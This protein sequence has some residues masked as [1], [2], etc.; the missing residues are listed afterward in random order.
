MKNA[1][2]CRHAGLAHQEQAKEGKPCGNKGKKNLTSCTTSN[3]PALIS[4][5]GAIKL[6]ILFMKPAWDSI[7]KFCF[8]K[9]R[10]VKNHVS[11]A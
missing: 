10:D 7:L 8:S 4:I 6:K 1:R 2:S 11:A 5:E 9:V 3:S